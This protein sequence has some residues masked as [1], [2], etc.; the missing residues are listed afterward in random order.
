MSNR[1]LGA[2]SNET[3]VR[4][5]YAVGDFAVRQAGIALNKSLSDIT[6]YSNRSMNFV[7]MWDPS[8]TSDGFSGQS[9]I[10]V[11]LSYNDDHSTY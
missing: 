1:A 4:H 7:N 5:Q 6:K 8:V 3:N 10:Y 11:G 9:L 2:C